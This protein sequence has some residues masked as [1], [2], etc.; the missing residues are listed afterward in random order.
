MSKSDAGIRLRVVF[1][2]FNRGSLP[3]SAS[4]FAKLC[5]ILLAI[6]EIVSLSD[7]TFTS[8]SDSKSTAKYLDCLN[9]ILHL[10]LG[11]FEYLALTT[12]S[13]RAEIHFTNQAGNCRCSAN[14]DPKR[15]GVVKKHSINIVPAV[16]DSP[17]S[18][19]F[20]YPPRNLSLQCTCS[21]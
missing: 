16:P 3:K 7:Q 9:S 11:L 5:S 14:L 12:L 18:S 15:T 2:H 1:K 19:G 8:L 6:K 21:S 17:L 20:L 4:T 13:L 10:M